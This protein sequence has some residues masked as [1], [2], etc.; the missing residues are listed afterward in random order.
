VLLDLFKTSIG[1]KNQIRGWMIEY[2]GVIAAEGGRFST[3]K[4][5]SRTHRF[6]I[7]GLMGIDDSNA[8]EKTF[9]AI[10][11][12][13]CDTLDSDATI[14]AFAAVAPVLVGFSSLTEFGFLVHSAVIVLEVTEI[15]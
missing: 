9:S 8:S 7:M 10:A 14:Q 2:R 12:D 6:E 4:R 15:I 11:E 5:I 13:V 3:T 1:G